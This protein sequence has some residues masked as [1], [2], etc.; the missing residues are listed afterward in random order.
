MNDENDLAEREA[1]AW[2]QWTR[3]S[4]ERQ[5]LEAVRRA[6]AHNE[7]WQPEVERLQWHRQYRQELQEEAQAL[8]AARQKEREAEYGPP[9]DLAEVKAR[10][11]QR[12]NQA[13]GIR[14]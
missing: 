7:A 5:Q 8:E 10:V 11:R 2:K 4:Q 12:V 3:I 9:P 6:A 13:L 1:E 14:D